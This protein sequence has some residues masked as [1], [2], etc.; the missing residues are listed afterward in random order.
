MLTRAAR[1]QRKGKG[2][3]MAKGKGLVRLRLVVRVLEEDGSFV[4]RE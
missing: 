1:R 4:T 3:G 2:D